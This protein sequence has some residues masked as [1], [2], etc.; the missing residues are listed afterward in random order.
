V[1]LS[2][3]L[4]QSPLLDAYCEISYLILLMLACGI[5][6]V[7]A[8]QNTQTVRL[9]WSFLAAAFGLWALV[10]WAWFYYFVLHRRTPVFLMETFPS[11]L[12]IVLMVA[13]VLSRPHLKLPERRP[14]RTTLNFLILL[15]VG[16]AAYGYVLFPYEY[17]AWA[18]A[19]IRHYEAFTSQKTSCFSR[20]WVC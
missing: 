17:G 1:A 9:F 14:Y 8:T 19:T 20:F 6:T 3:A 10:P 5:A 4:G 12:H 18:G 7:N 16:V 11:F 13:A 2:I 15:F